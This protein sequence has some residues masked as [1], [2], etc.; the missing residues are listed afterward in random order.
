MDSIGT[1]HAG[2]G[3]LGREECEGLLRSASVGRLAFVSDGEVVVVPVNFRFHEGTIVIRT[4][5][6][7]KLE[8]AARHAQMTFEIDGW[9]DVTETGWSVLAKGGAREVLSDE[10]AADLMQLGLRPWADAAG[11]R[12]WLR[13]RPDEITGRKI[14]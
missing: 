13:I 7:S 9:N 4:A 14:E 6:G 12:R 10:E 2:L 1:D 3:I 11:K 8:A 5:V